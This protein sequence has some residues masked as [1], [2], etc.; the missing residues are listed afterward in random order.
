MKIDNYF[1]LS[2]ETRAKKNVNIPPTESDNKSDPREGEQC[3]QVNARQSQS[4]GQ[5]KEEEKL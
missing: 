1:E 3:E 2:K 4:T 5:K